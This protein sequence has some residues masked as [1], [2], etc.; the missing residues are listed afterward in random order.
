MCEV[1][2]KTVDLLLKM[3]LARLILCSWKQLTRGAGMML[4]FLLFLSEAALS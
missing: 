2:L 1:Y 4:R 3:I